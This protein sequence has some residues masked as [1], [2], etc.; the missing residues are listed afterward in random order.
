MTTTTTDPSSSLSSLPRWNLSRFGFESPFSSE[1]DDHLEDSKTRAKTFQ[2]AYEGKLESCNLLEA[3]Q[4]FEAIAVR[5]ATVSSYLNLSYDVALDDDALK[6]RKGAVSQVQSEIT[7]NHLEW[8]EL[9]IAYL[10]DDAL[11]HH[12]T[13]T[14]ELVTKYG[15]YLEQVR[16]QRPHNVDKVVE[17]ALTVRA[18]Y[19]GTRPLVSFLD[20][21]LSLMRFELGN[22][23]GGEE[24]DQKTKETVNMEVLLS[25][26]GSSKDAKFRAKCLKLLNNGLQNGPVCRVASLSLSSVAGS[27]LIENKERKYPNL[28][29][30][31]NLD[32][33]CPDAVVDSLLTGVRTAGL[34]LCKQYYTIKKQIL[35]QTQGLETFRWSDRNAPMDIPT[36]TTSASSSGNN[37]DDEEK[38]EDKIEWST[39]V[40]IVERG[41]RKFSPRMAELFLDMIRE[42]RID[43]PAMN[44]K[45]GGAYCA[46][47]VPGIGPFQLLNFDGTKQD[48]ATLA[49]ESGH[50]CH[51]LLAYSRGYL[52]YHPPLTLAE[53]ASIFGEMIVFRDLL[54][55]AQTPQEKWTLLMSKIDDVINSVVRQCCFDR[56]EELAHTARA[57]GEL[58]TEEL[59]QFWLQAME[60]YYG[61]AGKDSPFDSYEDSSHLWSYVPHFHHVPFYVYSY[62][63]A[64]LV[65]GTLYHSFQTTPEGFEDRLLELLSAGGTKDFATALAPFGLD[66]T[67][68]TFWE[69]ALTAHLGGLV[70]EAKRLASTLGYGPKASSVEG[71]SISS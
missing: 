7:S 44:G 71:E 2:D 38:K 63:F 16:R 43:V 1:I 31:R 36:S 41:Y 67:S 54:E 12:Y 5:G 47:V 57:N 50:G 35:Q 34:P 10:S 28:R 30:R 26:L 45:K 6:K 15:S 23:S 64:D 13:T 37:G 21:E 20:K 9:D 33:N 53:T 22:G 61:K 48:V 19:A 14:P 66:P 49:H 55:L 40:N 60:E 46:G 59:D 62:A 52:Q 17:R 8:F 11:Q 27:W 51:D 29:S 39:A 24:D 42:E 69:D 70:E 4:E 65:V 58:S 25:R 32:N 68:P 3:I 56:F 18:P